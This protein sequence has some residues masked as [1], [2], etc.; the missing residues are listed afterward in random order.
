[1]MAVQS[2]SSRLGTKS[3]LLIVL[4]TIGIISVLFTPLPPMALDFLSICNVGIA[5]LILLLTFYSEKPLSFSTFPSILLI[6][7]LFRLALN[8]SA[9][10]LILDDASAG[11]VIGA[12]GEHVVGGNYVVGV[13]VFVILI[14]VQYV[15]VTAGAQRVAEVAARFTL[16]SMPG[17]QMSIDADLNI[18]VIDEQEARGSV[19]KYSKRP[20]FTVQWMVRPSL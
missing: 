9:T 12:I 2:V 11:K 10:R 18:G 19:R 16:D 4:A 13:V 3:D 15:V 6:T 20:T 14:V 8:I 1:M 5:L 17:K 7:T